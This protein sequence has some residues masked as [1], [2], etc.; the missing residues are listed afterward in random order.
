MALLATALRVQA[1]ASKGS[2]WRPSRCAPV[3]LPDVDVDPARLESRKLPGQDKVDVFTGEGKVSYV[4]PGDVLFDTDQASI[5]PDA[6]EGSARDRAEDQG[7]PPRTRDSGSRATPTTAATRRTVC[8]CPSA[9]PRRS[10]SWLIRTESFKA[11]L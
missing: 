5:R 4:A 10:P 9:G 3:R 7:E 6:C 1:A 2:R 8:G 11:G